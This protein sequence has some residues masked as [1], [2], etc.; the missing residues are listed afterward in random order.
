M[1]PGEL[2]GW[3]KRGKPEIKL[4]DIRPSCAHST[5]CERLGRVPLSHWALSRWI[6]VR[7]RSSD[8]PVDRAPM[9]TMRTSRRPGFPADSPDTPDD[10]GV[11]LSAG[12]IRRL[13]GEKASCSLR[14]FNLRSLE[15]K[16]FRESSMKNNLRKIHSF[17]KLQDFFFFCKIS[18]A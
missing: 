2:A 9:K 5:G 14:F 7:R 11:R 18:W 6:P 16:F 13:E 15:G 8:L 1:D 3:R 4:P 10:A 12:S 17:L